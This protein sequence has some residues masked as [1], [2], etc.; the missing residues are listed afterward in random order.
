MSE[1]RMGGRT[2][3]QV[4]KP[5]PLKCPKCNKEVDYLLGEAED[6]ACEACFDASTAK[7]PEPAPGEVIATVGETNQIADVN[8]NLSPT[9]QEQLESLLGNKNRKGGV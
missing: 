1:T 6:T 5:E 7:T 8:P 9:Q 2:V 4:D 3:Y